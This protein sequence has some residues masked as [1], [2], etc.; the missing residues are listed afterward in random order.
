MTLNLLILTSLHVNDICLLLIYVVN[1]IGHFQSIKP[2]A[3]L[4]FSL[5]ACLKTDFLS[6]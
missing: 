3:L 2:A 5:I 4:N 6:S 1:S